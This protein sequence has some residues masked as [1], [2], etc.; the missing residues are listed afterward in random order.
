MKCPLCEARSTR[1][2]YETPSKRYFQCDRC[3]L[4]W[5]DPSHRLD[6]DA[7][8]QE[9]LLHENSPDDPGYR[10][11][12][13]RALH[14]L[15]ERIA[16]QSAGLDFGCGP[17]PTLSV[18]LA[19]H[20][21]TVAL[22][23]PFFFPDREPLAQ[24]YDFITATEVVEH[25]HQPGA[26]LQQLVDGLRPGGWLIIMTKRVRDATAFAS[27]HY[28]NDPTH[29]CFFHDESFVWL[30]QHLNLHLDVIGPDVVALQ[31]PS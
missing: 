23:D 21:H 3:A 22:Y 7:E 1:R 25:L 18:M 20:G 15:L 17:G 8:R 16:P 28:K 6:A 11:F 10:Q 26:V 29:V 24:H 31:K 27:W 13:S 4:V 19:E 12:L 2:F 30:A 9:Y 14:P 5:L